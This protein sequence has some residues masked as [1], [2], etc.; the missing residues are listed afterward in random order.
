L[1]GC[2]EFDH[3]FSLL[4]SSYS[5]A[6]NLVLSSAILKEGGGWGFSIFVGWITICGCMLTCV[7]S[8]FI[9]TTRGSSGTTT[10]NGGGTDGGW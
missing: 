4:F 6:R 9:T 5:W 2:E 3:R 7:S 10:G 8:S 1:N